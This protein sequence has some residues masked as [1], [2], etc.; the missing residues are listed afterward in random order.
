MRG[1][2]GVQQLFETTRAYPG[3]IEHVVRYLLEGG[4]AEDTRVK[5]PDLIAVRL[6]MLAQSTRD[7]LRFVV[8]RLRSE[9]LLLVVT[10][11]SDDVHR[12]HPLRPVIAELHRLEAEIQQGMRELEG[13]L[14]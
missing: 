7:V 9:H 3:H 12:R 8:A 14:G 6:S 13:M 10:Y 1:L 5:L 4:K 2:P 11:R